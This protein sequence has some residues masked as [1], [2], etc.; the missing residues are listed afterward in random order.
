MLYHRHCDKEGRDLVRKFVTFHIYFHEALVPKEEDIIWANQ[1]IGGDVSKIDCQEL[2]GFM[3]K[4]KDQV[5]FRYDASLCKTNPNFQVY[6][7]VISQKVQTYSE[8]KQFRY[9]IEIQISL[10][11]LFKQEIM[12][13]FQ[14]NE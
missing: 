12:I 8:T 11:C 2:E 9:Y 4:L 5:S 10:I 6:I 13:D 1:H 7:S 14:I 3:E